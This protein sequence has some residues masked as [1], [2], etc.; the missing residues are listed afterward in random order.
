MT[1]TAR[2]RAAVGSIAASALLLAG[3]FGSGGGAAGEYDPDEEIELEISWWG[4]DDRAR[5]FGEVIDLFEAEHPN[6]TVVETPVGAPDDLFNRLATDF[7]G[8]GD[9]APDVFALGGAK[10]QEYGELGALLDLATVEAELD[11]ADYPDFSLTSALVD[12]TL[13]GLP[14][15][16][17]ATAAFVNADIFAQAGVPVPEEGW[18][19]PDLVAAASQIGSAGLTNAAGDSIYGIDLRIQ[20]ILGT[21]AAQVSEVGMYDWDGGLGVGADEIAGWYDIES[22][23]LAGG[24]LPDPSIVTANWQLP[25][26]QQPFTIGQAA[27]TFGYTNLMTAYSAAGDVRMLLPPTDTDLSGVAL[28]PSAYWSVNA[29]SPHPQAAAMLVDWFLHEPAAAELILDTRGVPFSPATLEVVTPHL[30]GPAVTAADYVERI[31]DEGVVAP[32]Q[33]AGGSIMNELSQ[34]METEV[35]FGRMSPDEAAAQ[36]AEEL[37]AALE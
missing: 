16:G 15:G 7:A 10:P 29:A 8:G 4:D 34:R 13:Y 21:Y 32:P 23:L 14:T 18:T 12:D 1:R 37:G 9:T 5:L 27:I 2:S 28:L 6:I 22:Q 33:P 36:W 11:T 35:L 19:W 24:G 31:F 20:D 3:C 30:E 26:D 17:N 25:P